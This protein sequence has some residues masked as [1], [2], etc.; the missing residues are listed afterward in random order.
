MRMAEDRFLLLR[1]GPQLVKENPWNYF[2]IDMWVFS[3]Y[4]SVVS[5]VVQFIYRY[6]VVC[7]YVRTISQLDTNLTKRRH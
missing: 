3:Y 6:L 1:T 5:V 2:L 7:R 4:Y